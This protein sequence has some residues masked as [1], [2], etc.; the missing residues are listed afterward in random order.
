M[1]DRIAERS[2]EGRNPPHVKEEPT[3][4]RFIIYDM[5]KS[6]VT[7]RLLEWS[8]GRMEDDIA[9]LNELVWNGIEA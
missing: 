6:V 1:K 7:Q 4:R 8:D 5:V 3:S 9:M 2:E